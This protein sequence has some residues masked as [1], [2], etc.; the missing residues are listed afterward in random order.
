MIKKTNVFLAEGNF[1]LEGSLPFD[2]GVMPIYI[3]YKV[4]ALRNRDNFI[5]RVHMQIEAEVEVVMQ[6][7]SEAATVFANN[8]SAQRA[9]ALH[10]C[11]AVGTLDD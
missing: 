9:K 11:R 10:V 8:Y 4:F 3:N 2:Q 6:K 5:Y 7:L 1:P